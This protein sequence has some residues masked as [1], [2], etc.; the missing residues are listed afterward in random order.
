MGMSS[1][2]LHFLLDKMVEKGIVEKCNPDDGK[3]PVYSQKAE[4]VFIGYDPNESYLDIGDKGTMESLVRVYL[5]SIGID[6]K[7]LERWYSNE[8]AKRIADPV[9]QCNYEE[10]VFFAKSAVGKVT[11]YTINL[12]SVNPLTVIIAGDS[13]LKSYIDMVCYT[14]SSVICQVS[15][16]NLGI[17]TIER[18][19]FDG[20]KTRFKVTFKHSKKTIGS[21]P[22]KNIT[23]NQSFAIIEKNG[24]TNVVTSSIQIEILRFLAHGPA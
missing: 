19:L 13:T 21:A 20:D 14:F 1:S 9:E 15:G 11:G 6:A 17:D 23:K 4:T 22:I 24:W 10:S 7:A 5:K 16:T 3:R 18:L 8:L 12:F 2:S